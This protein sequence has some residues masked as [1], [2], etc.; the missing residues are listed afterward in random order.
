MAVLVWFNHSTPCTCHFVPSNCIV[1]SL[2]WRYWGC[3]SKRWLQRGCVVHNDQKNLHLLKIHTENLFE[4]SIFITQFKEKGVAESYGPRLLA[5]CG[6]VGYVLFCSGGA[7]AAPRAITHA[8]HF[9]HMA[10]WAPFP[11]S[12]PA[13]LAPLPSLHLRRPWMLEGPRPQPSPLLRPREP[14]P[15][16]FLE[17][18]P[19]CASPAWPFPIN[20]GCS[21]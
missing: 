2:Q 4:I 16:L 15:I 13:S 3:A 7:E 19:K 8:R 11:G 12:S 9:A 1:T 18:F 20:S 10:S 14:L 21:V 6:T 5:A 17:Q